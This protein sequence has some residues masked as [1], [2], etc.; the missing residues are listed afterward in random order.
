M[1][2]VKLIYSNLKG[3][4]N[5]NAWIGYENGSLRFFIQIKAFLCFNYK[6]ICQENGNYQFPSYLSLF[7][8]SIPV[9]STDLK[10]YCLQRGLN[11][12]NDGIK[13]KRKW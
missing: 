8:T 12:E 6:R 11:Y 5:G 4:L 1:D 7:D 13:F 10:W 3:A 9:A 2:I